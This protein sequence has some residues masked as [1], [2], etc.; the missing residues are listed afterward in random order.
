MKV[1]LLLISIVFLLFLNSC[2]NDSKSSGKESQEVEIGDSINIESKANMEATSGAEIEEEEVEKVYEIISIGAQN[3]MSENL[4]TSK[5]ANGE[6]IP[7][8]KSITEWKNAGTAKTPAWCYYKIGYSYSKKYGNSKE[9]GKLYNYWAVIDDR[10]LA[11][12]GWHIPS[13]EEWK[14]C[15]DNFEYGSEINQ[16]LDISFWGSRNGNGTFHE[17][18]LGRT[19]YYWSS[20]YDGNFAYGINFNNEDGPVGWG[21]YN[22]ENGRTVWALESNSV[23]GHLSGTSDYNEGQYVRCLK[24]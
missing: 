3:W 23:S 21:R 13:L 2:K 12:K 9:F 8:A 24:D 5:F 14:I 16:I 18:D 7:Q 19:I 15:F 1:K 10:G 4:N 22:G 6:E 11:P 20:K 17:V